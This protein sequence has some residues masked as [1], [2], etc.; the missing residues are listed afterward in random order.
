MTASTMPNVRRLLSGC[1]P[2]DIDIFLPR[3]A[4]EW[5]RGFYR[6]DPLIEAG[7]LHKRLIAQSGAEAL[8]EQRDNNGLQA[9][10]VLERLNWDS[11]HFG[12]EVHRVST[13]L[14]DIY[15]SASDRR[16]TFEAMHRAV[17]D[18]ARSCGAR[19]L[20]RRLR[21][22]RLD[23]IRV[24]EALGYR[25]ADNVVTM[26]TTPVA[27]SVSL[28]AG[29]TVR[30]LSIIDVPIAQSL[31][32]GSF[33][34]SRFCLEPALAARGEAVYTQW[35]TNAFSDP[36]HPP[37]GRVV[38]C[39]GQFAGFTLWTRDANVDIDVGCALASL[40]LFIV[41]EHWRRRGVGTAL[42]TDTLRE[43]SEAGAE[44]VEASTWIGQT[45][46][47]ATYQKIGFMVRENLLSFY[48]DLEKTA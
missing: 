8:I 7:H 17:L 35:L 15:L 48:L 11:E 26:T 23:E 40:D 30:P 10:A 32:A 47:M 4:G 21:S 24:L 19:L 20:L 45:A 44:K 13:V 31:M 5:F 38:E 33:S 16:D 37:L 41:G 14:V 27:Q 42:L 46:A 6:N 43:M 18:A 12:L 3:A 2:E 9:L 34:L 29:I 1:L 36:L 22:N 28:P 39:D 25:L